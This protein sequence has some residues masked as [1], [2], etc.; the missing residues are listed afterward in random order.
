M[1]FE[2]NDASFDE[3]FSKIKM[4]SCSG[5]G[6]GFDGLADV[7]S[8]TFVRMRVICGRLVRRTVT[9]D[10]D[11]VERGS[12]EDTRREVLFL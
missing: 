10:V 8:Y 12:G 1:I 9:F 4:I 7:Y 2:E 11:L 3:V 5:D 6:F